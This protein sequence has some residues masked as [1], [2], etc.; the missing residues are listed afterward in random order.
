MLR[1]QNA[2]KVQ[3]Y[4][5][6]HKLFNLYY[7]V[8]TYI[9]ALTLLALASSPNFIK[10]VDGVVQDIRYVGKDARLEVTASGRLHAHSC[11][12][13]VGTTHIADRLVND[14]YLE[15]YTRTHHPFEHSGQTWMAVEILPKVRARFFGMYETHLHAFANQRGAAFPSSL[16]P[17]T[18]L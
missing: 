2:V 6:S 14:D 17:H 10:F 3:E 12:R 9:L 4:Y 5:L 18:D 11:P 13:E 15:M 7:C 8:W 16:A 1:I